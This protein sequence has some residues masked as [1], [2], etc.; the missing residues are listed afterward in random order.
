MSTNIFK[1][2][3]ENN[4]QIIDTVKSDDEVDKEI[5][6]KIKAVYPDTPIA[7]LSLEIKMLR[8]GV[9]NPQDAGFVA[10]NSFI[11]ACRAEGAAAKNANAE[12]LTALKQIEVGEGTMKS[13]V[14]VVE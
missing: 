7:G 9:T 12:K 6:A 10:Y 11:N 1:L 13:K 2:N 14:Y 3:A 4:Y 5:F 8:L